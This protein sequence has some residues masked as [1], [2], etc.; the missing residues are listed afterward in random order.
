MLYKLK[1]DDLKQKYSHKILNDLKEISIS[2]IEVVVKVYEK[3]KIGILVPFNKKNFFL[4]L[5]ENKVA[6]YFLKE[7]KYKNNV[8][9]INKKIDIETKDYLYTVTDLLENF[10]YVKNKEGVIELKCNEEEEFKW[11]YVFSKLG[12][13]KEDGIGIYDNHYWFIEGLM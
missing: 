4:F 7:Y 10:K 9:F 13:L 2:K 5:Y 8:Y 11:K 6:P 12:I 1:L 3:S